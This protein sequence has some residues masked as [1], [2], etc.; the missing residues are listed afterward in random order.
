MRCGFLN[1]DDLINQL[2]DLIDK[3]DINE[4][5][6]KEKI[7]DEINRH[8]KFNT[9]VLGLKDQKINASDIDIRNYAKHVLKDGSSIEKRDILGCLKSKIILKNKIII[10]S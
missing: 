8:R 9:N 5:G 6:I 4:I 2:Q 1:E 7:R 3:I 10:L